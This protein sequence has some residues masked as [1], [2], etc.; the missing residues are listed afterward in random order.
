[1]KATQDRIFLKGEADRY[2]LRNR[3][4]LV[5][6]GKIDWPCNT[7]ALLDPAIRKKIK[8]V[9]ELGCAN[10]WRLARL[11]ARMPGRYVGIEPSP[12]A[13]REGM[14][15]YRGLE[16]STGT[17]EK[18]SLKEEFDLV[19]VSFVLHWVDRRTLA[20]SIAGIDRVVKDGGYLLLSDFLPDA[21]S[22]RR[23]GHLPGQ[24]VFTYKQDYA[25]VF[26][27]LN[28]YQELAR[29]IFDADR[30]ARTTAP[31]P[32]RSRCMSVLLHKSLTGRYAAE[33]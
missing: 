2:F 27:A 9:V 7:L 15:R 22:R 16:L 8:T 13:V 25:D 31:A 19:V 26:K 3:K 17:L 28:S 1:M 24:D 29:L 32:S 18:N 5:K 14:R 23:Y 4:A 6:K 11:R 20:R 12:E 21:P 30:Y 10:G 33:T